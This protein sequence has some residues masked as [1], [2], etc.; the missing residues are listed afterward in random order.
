[1]DEDKKDN[2]HTKEIGIERK[3]NTCKFYMDENDYMQIRA[4]QG[5]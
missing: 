2:E 1:M 4:C 3:I 5:W